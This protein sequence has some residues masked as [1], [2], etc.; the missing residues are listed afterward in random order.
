MLIPLLI[1]FFLSILLYS[2]FFQSSSVYEGMDVS[3]NSSST[4]QSYDPNNA[5]ILAQQN[6][7]N[8][9][10]IMQRLDGVQ[11][12]VQ[13][14][15]DISGNVV[16]LQQQVNGLVS[17]QNDYATQMTGGTAPTITGTNTIGDDEDEEDT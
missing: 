11:H 1:V 17:A 10:Y 15:E 8:I 4:Y 14:V 12:L 6:A 16:S 2:F 7:G 13:E 3:G 9:E 5:L